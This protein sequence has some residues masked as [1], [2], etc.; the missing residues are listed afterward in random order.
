MFCVD[1]RTNSEFCPTHY[2]VTG[3]YNRDGKCL[4]RGTN[5]DFKYRP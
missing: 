5:W 1:V 2:S 4:L 3:F